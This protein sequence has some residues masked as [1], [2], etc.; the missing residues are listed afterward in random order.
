MSDIELTNCGAM[1]IVVRNGHGNSISRPGKLSKFIS[2]RILNIE[3]NLD[4]FQKQ[5]NKSINQ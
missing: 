5:V 2:M 4:Y 3:M 1:L